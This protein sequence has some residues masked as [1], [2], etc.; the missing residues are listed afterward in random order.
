MK[1]KSPRDT[2]QVVNLPII[3]RLNSQER[4]VILP[5]L[6]SRWK[7]KGNVVTVLHRALLIAREHERALEARERGEPFIEAL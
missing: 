2:S 5:Y 6:I 4:N 1:N 3:F 7:C